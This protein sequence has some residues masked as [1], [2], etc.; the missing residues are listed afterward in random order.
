MEVEDVLDEVDD[1]CG[2]ND[3]QH[4]ERN[5]RKET[6]KDRVKQV[7]E[8]YLQD[9]HPLGALDSILLI[10]GEVLISAEDVDADGEATQ[11]PRY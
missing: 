4:E 6:I 8:G 2:H 5:H 7:T 11:T 3:E 9:S 1:G 10:E